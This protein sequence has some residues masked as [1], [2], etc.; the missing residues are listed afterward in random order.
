MWPGP[1]NWVPT[2]PISAVTSSSWNTSPLLPN[3][4]PVGVPGILSSK[5]R[6]PKNGMSR[7]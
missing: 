1:S 2:W 7:A 3:G 5:P 6:A 4:P